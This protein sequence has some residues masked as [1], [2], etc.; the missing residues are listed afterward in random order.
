MFAI[1]AR[2]AAPPAV[3]AKTGSEVF[4]SSASAPSLIIDASSNKNSKLNYQTHNKYTTS[5]SSFPNY[6]KNGQYNNTNSANSYRNN[7]LQGINNTN[8]Q[9]NQTM[10]NSNYKNYT[11]NIRCNN[12]GLPGHFSKNCSKPIT[13]YGVILLNVDCRQEMKQT[14]Y[15]C[16]NV[17]YKYDG[18]KAESVHSDLL[19]NKSNQGLFCELKCLI[20]F[21]MIARKH[22]IGYMEFLRGRYK[23]N[24]I[25][26]IQSLFRQM[27]PAEIKKIATLDFTEL[28]D[29]MWSNNT[30]DKHLQSSQH[31]NISNENLVSID[32]DRLEQECD[33]ICKPYEDHDI[34]INH[35]LKKSYHHDFLIAQ[36]KFEKIKNAKNIQSI[37]PLDWYIKKTKTQYNVNEWGFPKGRKNFKESNLECAV[38]EFSEETGLTND[39]F[40]ILENITPIEEIFTGTD[41][42]VYKYVYYIA[43]LTSDSV[44]LDVQALSDLGEV[45]DIGW[46]NYDEAYNNIRP[47]HTSRL[48]ILTNF[49]LHMVNILMRNEAI[50][51][52]L[53]DNEDAKNKKD[54]EHNIS[55]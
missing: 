5:F 53:Q 16:L 47:Y 33:K 34:N 45:G 50:N 31:A 19:M 49:H 42:I 26:G 46:F 17:P 29:D 55:I 21:L 22:S 35:G 18:N 51:N 14:V 12:C 25:D 38:R 52:I 40:V 9:T 54:K 7:S 28:W 30:K 37:F 32:P 4:K 15:D 20:Q 36:K 24:D 43:G 2:T 27:L 48:H 6:S 41:G 1:E 3:E 23:I 11:K 13:S 8:N 44:T 10:R 39:D